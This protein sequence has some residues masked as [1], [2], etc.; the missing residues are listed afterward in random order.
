MTN[1]QT[2]IEAFGTWLAETPARWPDAA[3][4]SAQ[5]E[6]IDQIGVT[7]AGAAEP[8]TRIAWDVV[9][10]WGDGPATAIGFNRGLAAPWAALVNGTSGH[11]LDF[12]DNFDPP[13]AHATT[14]LV[15]AILALAEQERAGGAALLDAYICGLQI[16][17]RVGQGVNPVHRNRGWH[18][19]ATVGAIGAAA[20]AARL[21]G[22]DANAAS[23]A[24]S[25]ATSMAAGFMSQFGTM[26]KPLHAGLAA[27]AGVMAAS[28]ARAG[29]TA[30]MN[31]LEGRT[32]MNHLMV[33]PDYEQLRDELVNPEHGQT[34]RF[35]TG[36]VGD[37]LLILEHGFRVKRF[38]N[39]GASHRAIDA[40]LFLRCTH[41][42][43]ADDVARVDVHLPQVH[44]NNLMY[45]RPEDGL[46]SKFSFPYCLAV[47]LHQGE[48]LLADFTDEGVRRPHIRALYDRIQLHPVDKLEGAFPT[49]VEVTLNTG[50]VLSET[51]EWPE[52]SKWKPFS[53]A[54][55]WDKF[56]DCVQGRLTTTQAEQ[57]R[58]ALSDLGA[59][60]DIDQL[61]TPLRVI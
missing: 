36:R 26:A 35:E 15:P 28:F 10:G 40:L 12:D 32:G 13:K 48:V 34:L 30:G 60:E 42:F 59:L 7:V 50:A 23:R 53:D 1:Q 5:R 55:Y 46:Q 38:A 51:R 19:T 9:G 24:L 11:A 56:N 41:G 31:T 58:R 57:V 54:Q 22:L 43:S 47:A 20:G 16:M 3:L 14:V 6:F 52:G 33:G 27:K 39:C 29:M 17:G 21:L 18:A 25:L 49:T 8:C 37:P 61:M 2:A 4:H 44:R 45:D